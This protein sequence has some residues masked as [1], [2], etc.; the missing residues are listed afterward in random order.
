MAAFI[1]IVFGTAC[2][3]Y[4]YVLTQFGRE[5]RVLRSQR[6]RGVPLV[7]PFRGMPEFRESPVTV[8]AIKPKVT[9]LPASGAVKR[10]VA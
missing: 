9:V 8:V 3:F 2:L 10:D 4:G 5:I 6:A 1:A 7:T